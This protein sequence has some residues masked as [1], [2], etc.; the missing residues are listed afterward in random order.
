MKI[1]V[2]N[3]VLII[4]RS[5]LISQR[6]FIF[7][8]SES[9]TDVPIGKDL[10]H[11]VG[12][13]ALLLQN[14]L[15]W[16]FFAKRNQILTSSSSTLAWR[17]SVSLP[18]TWKCASRCSPPGTFVFAH[19]GHWSEMKGVTSDT[20]QSQSFLVHIYTAGFIAPFIQCCTKVLAS[21]CQYFKKV[22]TFIKTVLKLYRL[23][24]SIVLR[25]DVYKYCS[26]NSTSC[27]KFNP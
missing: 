8:C 26:I 17:R 16:P 21:V 14:I 22:L 4:T 15:F 7:R 18:L 5:R 2:L 11:I 9:S 12:W 10:F 20:Q 25:L 27:S 1:S 3:G 24:Y 19:G 23:I 13:W 6:L